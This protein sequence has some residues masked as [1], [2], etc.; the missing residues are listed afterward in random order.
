[1]MKRRTTKLKSFLSAILLFSVLLAQNV[2]VV[3]ACG[4][5]TL[6]PIF[7]FTRHADY[8]LREYTNGSAGI[9]PDSFGRMSLFVFYRQLNN[10]PLT[11]SEQKQVIEAMRLRIGGE[12]WSNSDSSVGNPQNSPTEEKPDYKK[13]WQSARAKILGDS[14]KIST[15][16]LV[17]DDYSYFQNCLPDAFKNAANTL[18]MRVAKYGAADVNVKEWLTGQD[19][20]FSNCG[21][22]AQ[23]PK[24]LSESS[25]EWL[26]KDRQYQ[27]AGAL[28]YSNKLSESRAVF[29]QIAAD[30][31]SVW[32]KTARF[33]VA[34]TYIREASF[35][36]DESPDYA[37]TPS[38][39]ANVSSNTNII[40]NYNGNM[41]NTNISANYMGN[42]SNTSAFNTSISNTAPRKEIKSIDE[43]K[44][45]KN[46]L[47]QKARIQLRN[48]LADPS[49]KDFHA[50]AQRL[51][52]LVE[53]RSNPVQRSRELARTLTLP[54][55]N[56]NMYNDLTDYVWLLDRVE[57]EARETG[58]EVER[59]EAEKT[60][61][62]IQSSYD[63]PVKIRDVPADDLENE[64]T[65][66]LFTYQSP[67]GFNHAFEKWRAIQKVYWLVPA[68]L[69]AD[70]K[71]P[72]LAE[73]LTA[74]EKIPANSP[75]YATVR[76]HQIRLLL[77]TGKKSEAR[78]KIDE[79]FATDLSKYNISTQ[80]K[81]YSQRMIFAE[82]LDDFLKYA[83]RRAATFVW[84]DDANEE[85]TDLNSPA[86]FD[87]TDQFDKKMQPWARRT[88]FDE[89]AVAFF[90]EK[91]PLSVLRQAALSRQLPE[92]LKKFLVVAVWTRAFILKNQVVE[93]EFT[94]LMQKYAPDFNPQ[95]SKYAVASGADREA[96]ALMVVLHYP[97]IQPF[98]PVG[99][100]RESSP[101]A[102]IDS[103]RG[104]WW[105]VENENEEYP[106]YYDRYQFKH[107]NSYPQFL[108]PAQVN[109]AE[110]EQKSLIASGN[111]ATHLTRRAVAFATQ[112]PNHAD[113]PE[114]LHLA[115]RSTRYG[116]K[117]DETLNLS[118][119][120]F[121]IL[122][123]RYPNSEW[124]KK[125]PYYF[126]KN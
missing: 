31:N 20:V 48:I 108:T 57:V 55:E 59:K 91:M 23:I 66:W 62:E 64:L 84:S 85:G 101:V 47:L 90:N 79:V 12:H 93:R 32:N 88:M 123:R 68:L 40:T 37:P 41:S 83:Q 53:F 120:A 109:E 46:N 71:S 44:N 15:E 61:K 27:I 116:C 107:P 26:K 73:V 34:R 99:Y 8:P 105:C 111:S 78:Q 42:I 29:E 56:P 36:D 1:M 76:F 89:D 97:V 51:L 80:N 106:V 103:N 58:I 102:T 6:D 18:E 4:P 25:P 19:A 98:V 82:N 65:D 87:G 72:Q 30:N 122:H 95:F 114:I 113:V 22:T 119:Q 81:F 9:V 69:K 39:A 110:R 112:N 92:H 49:M 10:A 125:T 54:T 115:V 21:A 11:P 35:I 13:I 67:D 50:S 94:P 16:K 7:S 63:S 124:T 77:E 2:S 33:V 24:E 38:M 75:A 74:A 45:D 17:E 126:G 96:A 52:N 121:Q 43:K 14:A 70:A 117:D 104:N 60:G 5:F 86:V 100:G 28:F 3:R 118:K